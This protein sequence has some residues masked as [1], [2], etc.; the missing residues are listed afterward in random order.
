MDPRDARIFKNAFS[1]IFRLKSLL[2]SRKSYCSRNELLLKLQEHYGTVIFFDPLLSL[3]RK[4]EVELWNTVFK[5]PL[6][7]C[8]EELRKSSNYSNVYEYQQRL[9]SLIDRAFGF[10]STLMHKLLDRLP[11]SAWT[12]N[13]TE[14]A[15]TVN[16]PTSGRVC[17]G[18]G[19]FDLDAV[20]LQTQLTR[21]S[22]KEK[23]ALLDATKFVTAIEDS[24]QRPIILPRGERLPDSGVFSAEPL[25]VRK[26]ATSPLKI[27]LSEAVVYL[28]QHCCIHLGDL[29]RYQHQHKIAVSYYVSAWLIDPTCGHAYNQLGVIE[30]T[31]TNP[32]MDSLCY[33]YVRAIACSFPFLFSRRNLK[34]I[35]DTIF[36]STK[37]DSLS[38]L[39]SSSIQADLCEFLLFPLPVF[40]RFHSMASNNSD[41]WAI[42][43]AAKEFSLATSTLAS[44]IDGTAAPV[45]LPKPLDELSGDFAEIGSITVLPENL[46]KLQVRLLNTIVIHSFGLQTNWSKENEPTLRQCLLY[47]TVSL[48]NWFCA[49]VMA[50][51]NK[52]SVIKNDLPIMP[53]LLAVLALK[54]QCSCK[55]TESGKL[56]DSEILEF[57]PPLSKSTIDFLNSLVGTISSDHAPVEDLSKV[58]LP[59]LFA[60]QG[61]LPMGIPAFKNSYQSGPYVD[62]MPH[63]FFDGDPDVQAAYFRNR[64]S[65]IVDALRSVAGELPS[66]LKWSGAKQAFA[67]VDRISPSLP[68]LSQPEIVEVASEMKEFETPEPEIS[69]E[70]S[71]DTQNKGVETGSRDLLED[72]AESPLKEVGVGAPREHATNDSFTSPNPSSL[73][74]PLSSTCEPRRMNDINTSELA[75]FI[76]EQASQVAARQRKHLEEAARVDTTANH[77]YPTL[78]S[79]FQRDLPPRFSRIHEAEAIGSNLILFSK[80]W[81]RIPNRNFQ[82]VPS[83]TA[84]PTV[85]EPSHLP[86]SLKMGLLSSQRWRFPSSPHFT[87]PENWPPHF[88]QP[89]PPPPPY[90]PASVQ[91]P[92]MFNWNVQDNS[93]YLP[94]NVDTGNFVEASIYLNKECVNSNASILRNLVAGWMCGVISRIECWQ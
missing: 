44:M 53:V 17:W 10:Y 7:T 57:A 62:L 65:L 23:A 32:R 92:Q 74:M 40:L 15:F 39:K 16:A 63:S 67:S 87:S 76:Q 49:V 94:Q 50:V 19:R 27:S 71:K 60:L 59:E 30:A 84:V 12:K 37:N 26:E 22:R 11:D 68:Q 34:S 29:A 61:F 25:S 80:T 43:S 20:T 54:A 83:G 35:M 64:V 42:V 85:F 3:E 8:I 72:I 82:T 55:K 31:K 90:L 45:D 18:G 14:T 93:Y 47:T 77:S 52:C 70:R 75:R 33:F 46:Q 78:R 89:P 81:D 38:L 13:I 9:V 6:N 66:L 2:P 56:S 24:Q 86:T 58:D 41:I 51:R 69:L 79:N 88:A 36:D 1:E 21:F 73:P 5:G 91:R 28:V 48:I 4:F